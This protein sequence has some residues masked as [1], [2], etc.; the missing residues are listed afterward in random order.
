VIHLD[1]PLV[2]GH[3]GFPTL[4]VENTLPSFVAALEAGAEGIEC[5]VRA[6]RDG[7]IVAFHDDDLRRLCGLPG[8]IEDLP[9]DA[10][11]ALAF[12]GAPAGLRVPPLEDVLVLARERDA[13]ALVEVKGSAEAAVAVARAA[14]AA[15]VRT[16]AAS[17]AAFL[18][19]APEVVREIRQRDP[20]VPAA[21]IFDRAPSPDE[22]LAA[23][24]AFVVVEA[25]AASA[26]LADALR[27]RGVALACYGVDDEAQDARLDAMGA[28]LRI[29]DRPDVLAA[30]RRR[31]AA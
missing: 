22:A 8:R 28:G 7:A 21:P 15:I 13:F 26:A 31:A 9:A 10:V 24:G 17:R 12:V 25:R 23:G 14:H 19:F 6:S 27:A 1:R 3:R 2:V 16:G 30:R 20:R 5:D 11:A 4:A 29:S 18:A